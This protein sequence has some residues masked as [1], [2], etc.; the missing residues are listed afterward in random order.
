MIAY[1][2]A[3]VRYLYANKLKLAESTAI[4]FFP[5]GH[6]IHLKGTA[7]FLK[8]HLGWPKDSN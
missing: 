8:R 4:E 2:Y 6:E 5:G 3:K 7:E 1:E